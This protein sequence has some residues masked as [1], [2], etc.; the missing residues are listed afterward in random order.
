M[1]ETIPAT[2][3]R[4]IHVKVRGKD[5]IDRVEVLRNNQVIYRDHPID[6]TIRPSE[7]E[8]P[9]LC[10]IEFGWGP[11]GDLNMARICDWRFKATV[12]NG[13]ILSATPCFQAG[14]FDEER[15]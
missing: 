4:R 14:P 11:W 7:W 15:Q 6:R 9:V 3:T 5:A 8:K 13:K 12:N 2:T 10:R 1:G